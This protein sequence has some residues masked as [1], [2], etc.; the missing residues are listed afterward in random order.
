[1]SKIVKVL[2]LMV[3]K[4]SGQHQL[5]SALVVATMTGVRNN[6]YVGQ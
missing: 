4:I 5:W 1:M 6:Y 2:Y 3:F